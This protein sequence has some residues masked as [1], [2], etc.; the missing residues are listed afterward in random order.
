MA[1][2][3]VY[4]AVVVRM[5]TPPKVDAMPLKMVAAL[6]QASD[7][8][9][10]FPA[11]AWQNGA[12]KRFQTPDA[13][14]LFENWEQRGSDAWKV[15]PVTIIFGRGMSSSD[16]TPPI[17]LES[18]EGAEIEFAD[19]LDLFGGDAPPIKRGRLNGHVIATRS[20]RAKSSSLDTIAS[21]DP[22]NHQTADGA[23]DKDADRSFRLETTNIVIDQKRL[24]T[25]API[26]MQLGRAR[27]QGRDLTL[28]LS[29][30]GADR[31]LVPD[32]MEL[33][34]LDEISLPIDSD[35]G[36][37]HLEIGCD[38]S[39][40]YDFAVSTLT[41]QDKVRIERI[42]ETE[43]GP[44]TSDQFLAE[45]LRLTL[46]GVGSRVKRTELTDWIELVTATGNPVSINLPSMQSSVLADTLM[47]NVAGGHFQASGR[48]GIEIQRDAIKARLSNI[49][50]R[51]PPD[52]PTAI[53]TIV[54]R[55]AGIINVAAGESMLK[56]WRWRETLEI[57]PDKVDA[58]DR[59]PGSDTSAPDDLSALSI[60]VDGGCD[61]ETHDGGS[62]HAEKITGRLIRDPDG[63]YK[64]QRVDISGQVAVDHQRVAV[65]TNRMQVFFRHDRVAD[66]TSRASEHAGRQSR[67]LGTDR[68]G[69]LVV[70]QPFGPGSPDSGR[71]VFSSGSAPAAA[72]STTK[73]SGPPPMLRGDLI[74]VE[75][76]S[77]GET[78]EPS[79]LSIDGDLS[80]STTIVGAA[81]ELPAMLRGR[82]MQWEGGPAKDIL[83]L[84]GWQDRPAVLEIGDGFLVG[85]EI[86]VRR[87]DNIIWMKDAGEFRL[88]SSVVAG[89]AK[90]NA[91][92]MRWNQPPHCRWQG[93][94]LFDGE[95]IRVDGGVDVTAQMQRG[96][97][98]QNIQLV[99][100]ELSASFDGAIDL[101]QLQVAPTVAAKTMMLTGTPQR[102]VFAE[103]RIVA[104]S[105]LTTSKHQFHAEQL[106]M[107]PTVAGGSINTLVGRGPG[108]YRGWIRSDSKKSSGANGSSIFPNGDA[109]G[110]ITDDGGV[111]AIRGIHLAFE[112]SMTGR[113][114][115][116]EVM[117]DGGVRVAMRDVSNFDQTFDALAI[118]SP[119]PGLSLVD[120]NTLRMA[121]NS[122]GVTN[123]SGV[124]SRP[125]AATRSSPAKGANFEVQ[126]DGAVRFQTHVKDAL[127]N[128]EAAMAT[129][130][131][132]NDLFVVR[133]LPGTPARVRTVRSDGQ[134]GADT[135]IRVLAI[136]PRE[137]VIEQ[138]VPLSMAMPIPQAANQK[139]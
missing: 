136:H 81:G 49:D 114:D 31:K 39:V 75:L 88:P 127:L 105:G 51:Y 71:S 124:T 18:A 9:D 89:Q 13:M 56:S 90:T 135:L 84:V 22:S 97:E 23:I 6:R 77:N 36:N 78:F 68:S 63:S 139:R 83:Q 120:C 66:P 14:L 74:A 5:L 121:M 28:H 95:T 42:W 33:I 94:M 70:S 119:P 118:G 76:S 35:L 45:D 103:T 26:Q 99:G 110:M 34:Y 123:R 59:A 96:S 4:D 93:E 111:T 50:Y 101:M 102:P 85:P 128:G 113:M 47:W 41:M 21:A 8:S 15:W 109:N 32:R 24:Y 10:L 133:G 86:Q 61:F 125:I 129:Y 7:L 132:S 87:L 62:G 117:F 58:G 79:R 37:E 138:F 80:L 106:Q 29:H 92:A 69:K 131:S 82:R 19:S 134:P 112:N 100:E 54:S 2:Y 40:E 65:R 91:P 16:S 3:F 98:N 55:G 52:D 64:P 46:R 17:V 126:A 130:A 60:F 67:N 122:A 72:A 48:R 107:Q 116:R 11:D 43:N 1:S 30:V 27:M 104:A 57:R 73:P 12:C 137:M 25:T 115:Q 108:W 53:G 38:G 44:R 20:G